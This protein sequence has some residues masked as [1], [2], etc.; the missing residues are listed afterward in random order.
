M[1]VQFDET[2]LHNI[3]QDSGHPGNWLQPES[4]QASGFVLFINIY[5]PHHYSFFLQATPSGNTKN[6]ELSVSR[7]QTLVRESSV[8]VDS[9]GD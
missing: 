8:T 9:V 3:C 1:C 6:P 5:M 7:Q 2:R 4:S